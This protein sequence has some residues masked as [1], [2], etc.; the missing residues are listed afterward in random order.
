MKTH[1]PIALKVEHLSVVKGGGLFSKPKA[2][3]QDVSFE[4]QPGSFVA[5]IG[6]NGAGKTTLFKA[7][8][9]EKPTH[10]RV[11]VAQGCGESV[12]YEDLYANPEYWLQ[13]IGY[14]PVDNVLHEE[15]TVRQ[16]LEHIGWLRLPNRSKAEIW[17]IITEKLRHLGFAEDDERLDRPVKSLSSGER[18]KVNIAAEL[19]T[20][21]P[22][23]LLDEPTSNLDPNAERDLMNALRNLAGEHN[24]GRGPTILIITHTLESL[25]RCSHVVFIANA[26]LLASGTPEQVLE[27]LYQ[28]LPLDARPA[29]DANAFEIWA[30]IFDYYKTVETTK[31]VQVKPVSL[32]PIASVRRER[33]LDNFSR[34]FRIL[35]SRYFLAR[36]NDLKGIGA[37]LWT[38]FVAGFLLLI[39]PS[40]IFLK[41]RDASAA[42]QTV[43]L[44]VILTVI[45]AAFNSHREIS[46]EFRIYIHERAKGLDPIAYLSSKIAWLA[47]VIG[48]FST[49]IL[50]ALMG[51]PI[52]RW[53]CLIFGL[54]LLSIGVLSTLY[55]RRLQQQL[56]VAQRSWRVIQFGVI[57]LPLLGAFLLQLQNKQLPTT[58][59][60]GTTAVEISIIATLL[61]ASI[62][63]LTTALCTSAA[64]GGNN[65]R[66]TQFATG[67]IIANVIMAFSALVGGT[68]TFRALFDALEPLAVTYFGYRGFASSISLYCWAGQFRFEE[69]NSLG[70]LVAVWMC[71]LMHFLAAAG[72]GVSLLRIQEKWTTRAKVLRA[73]LTKERVTWAFVATLI[74]LLCWGNFLVNQSEAYASLTFYDVLYGGDRYA[75][76]EPIQEAQPLQRLIGQ[77]SSSACGIAPEE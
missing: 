26:K 40:E 29:R 69:F 54:T 45:V 38:G 11:L 47:V 24:N 37:I 14:V 39:A 60:I 35:F 62:A 57:T 49:L 77:I 20:N 13:Q 52:A 33:Q 4:V 59:P 3:L 61:L 67:V 53:L 27:A 12:C 6:P 18:K 51:F 23:L 64:V 32:P 17:R 15:L 2:I 73:I 55:D 9:N 56:T 66:A 50:L 74:G 36:Y 43:V 21:P 1:L 71:L 25:D 70:H 72:L 41:A 10:G 19:L 76:I 42:R 31:D 44:C 48:C 22:L 68:P 28:S 5:V 46:K 8:V 16:A 75:R 63:A 34:Q 58:P 30:A 65:D 7:L